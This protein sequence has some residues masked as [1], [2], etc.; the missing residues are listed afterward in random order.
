MAKGLL[1]HK[2]DFEILPTSNNK[3]LLFLDASEYFEQ[4]DSP[5]LRVV[6]PGYK[7]Y[8]TINIEHGKINVISSNTLGWTEILEGDERLD[9]P[10]GIWKFTYMICPYDHLQIAKYYLRTNILDS[11][12]KKIYAF[13]DVDCELED[14]ESC[15]R[16]EL[17][18]IHILIESAKANA[19]FGK[20]DKATKDF[21]L[22]QGKVR[23][24]LDKILR[25]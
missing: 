11:Q 10:D 8:F 1:S 25:N 5:M 19:E 24:L 21:Q 15:I 3:V 23:R 18:E 22:A 7:K 4:P 12:L 17:I 2:L 16:T 6:S 13:I 9:L 14:R 20:I